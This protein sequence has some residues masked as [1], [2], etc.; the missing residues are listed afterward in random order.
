[1]MLTQFHKINANYF[2]HIKNGFFNIVQLFLKI[3]TLT[4][5]KIAFSLTVKSLLVGSL[6]LYIYVRDKCMF[7]QLQIQLIFLLPTSEVETK[8]ILCYN[9]Q[10]SLKLSGWDPGVCANYT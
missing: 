1:M 4:L 7:S 6:F 9:S 8:Y 10:H 3:S 2:R 5:T